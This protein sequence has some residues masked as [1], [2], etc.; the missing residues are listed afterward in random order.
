MSLQCKLLVAVHVVFCATATIGILAGFAGSL[1]TTYLL[2]PKAR[3]PLVTDQWFRIRVL[4]NVSKK[5]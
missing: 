5:I 1:P 2:L 3:T 4:G